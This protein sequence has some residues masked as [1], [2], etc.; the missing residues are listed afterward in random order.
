[1]ADPIDT[2]PGERD[3]REAS[4]ARRS[5]T[6]ALSPWLVLVGIGVLAAGAFVLSAFL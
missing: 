1:M 6:P 4:L 3:P 5:G 2:D